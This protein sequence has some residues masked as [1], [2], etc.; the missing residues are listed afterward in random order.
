MVFQHFSF[1]PQVTGQ[2]QKGLGTFSGVFLPSFLQ[3]VGVILYMRLSWLVGHTG[4]IPMTLIIT[5]SSTLLFITALSTTS[6]VTNMKVGSGGAYYII[7]RSLGIEFGSAVGILLCL[8]QMTSIALCVSGFSISLFSLFP[9]LSLSW[10]EIVTI[11]TVGICASYS[12][13]WAVRVQWGIFFSLILSL[14]SLFLGSHDYLPEPLPMQDGLGHSLPFW[15]AFALFFPATTGIEAGMAM[16]GDLK[17]PSR[18]LAIGSVSAVFVAYVMYISV[19]WFMHWHATPQELMG[20]AM[21]A[22]HLAYFG[23]IIIV[24]I[25]GATLSS[26]LGGMLGAPRTIRAVAQDRALPTFLR[27]SYGQHNEPLAATL[28]VF[29]LATVITL[30]SSIDQIIPL[31]TMICLSSYGLLNFIAF[32]ESL[33]QNPSWRPLFATPWWLS[34]IGTLGCLCA[35]LMINPGATLVVGVLLAALCLWTTQR[36]VDG[37]WDDMRYALFS[38]FALASTYRASRMPQTARTWRPHLLVFDTNAEHPSIPLSLTKGLTHN[39]GFSTYTLLGG[40]DQTA[41][42]KKL[43]EE[44]KIHSFIHTAPDAS[45]QSMLSIMS[46][47]GLGPFRPNLFLASTNL[48]ASSNTTTQWLTNALSLQRNALL[49]APGTQEATFD[50]VWLWWSEDSHNTPLALAL[51]YVMQTGTPWSTTQLT[52]AAQVANEHQR[53]QVLQSFDFYRTLTRLKHVE[54]AVF[55]DQQ[56][57]AEAICSYTPAQT[58]VLIPLPATP[59]SATIEKILRETEG[60]YARLFVA[61]G[62]KINFEKIFQE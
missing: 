28:V 52:F 31:L 41:T 5:L 45:L 8:S 29:C 37:N 60:P 39:R 4:I 3:M 36:K 16:S 47:Y 19:A 34:L 54:Q 22:R 50:K 6:I 53:T 35:M 2:P 32:F 7:S 46:H 51:Y 38:F 59:D 21:L 42:T 14:L 55:V 15:Q 20:N 57:H 61:T 40:V 30:Y 43:L 33:I 48:F 11:I 26:A 13:Q 12:R 62:E 23:S 25:W 58:L 1:A 49:Y 24:G 56:S 27:W 9:T 10:I 18:S 17:T 44:H